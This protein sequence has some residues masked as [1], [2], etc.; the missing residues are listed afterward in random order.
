MDRERH[1][2]WSLEDDIATMVMETSASHG[3][4]NNQEAAAKGE[5]QIK[6]NQKGMPS[7]GRS[8][9][10]HRM[11]CSEAGCGASF[12]RNHGGAPSDKPSS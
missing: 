1:W 9:F 11:Q 3:P 2:Y 7:S 12:S 8:P 4:E 10:G 5:G 6:G